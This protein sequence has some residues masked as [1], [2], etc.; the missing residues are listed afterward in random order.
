LILGVVLVPD[1][2]VEVE[3]WKGVDGTLGIRALRR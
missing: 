2:E 1:F 3:S